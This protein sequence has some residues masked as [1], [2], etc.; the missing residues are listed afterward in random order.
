MSSMYARTRHAGR[1]CVTSA[2]VLSELG[3]RL[4]PSL[5][6]LRLD[7]LRSTAELRHLL[8]MPPGGGDDD[9]VPQWHHLLETLRVTKLVFDDALLAL[10]RSRWLPALYGETFESGIRTMSW[11]FEANVRLTLPSRRVFRV[12]LVI[13]DPLHGYVTG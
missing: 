5:R 12:T 7:A 6:V 3:R 10:F 9:D 8:P 2:T 13:C 4:P 1:S 11:P